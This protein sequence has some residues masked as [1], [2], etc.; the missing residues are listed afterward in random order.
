MSP[1]DRAAR[2]RFRRLWLEALENRTLLA[3]CGPFDLGDGLGPKFIGD[4]VTTFIEDFSDIPNHEDPETAPAGVDVCEA[5]GERLF[6]HVPSEPV[7]VQ[8][9]ILDAG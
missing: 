4:G 6:T 8:R 7:L 9:H 3:H 1:Y 2:R 5:Q